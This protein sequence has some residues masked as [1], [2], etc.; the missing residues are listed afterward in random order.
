MQSINKLSAAILV[1]AGLI[2]HNVN[3]VPDIRLGHPG[4]GGNGCPQG[5]GLISLSPDKKFLSIVFEEFIVVAN[6]GRKTA[7]KSCNIA[8]PV[9]VPHGISISILQFDQR[10]FVSIP[11]NYDYAKLGAEYFF[12]GKRGASFSKEINSPGDYQ[13]HY[14]NKLIEKDKL[15]SPCGK[16]VTLRTST[17]MLVKSRSGKDVIGMISPDIHVNLLFNLNY[18]R[19]H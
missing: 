5:T 19:C 4:Y 3:A 2:S 12:A 13:F 11:T 15:W 10:G 17:N 6:K 7:R 18:K 16:D 8:I 9:K 14:T 1:V